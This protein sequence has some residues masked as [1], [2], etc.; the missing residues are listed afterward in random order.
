M[1]KHIK[2]KP[3]LVEYKFTPKGT[4]NTPKEFNLNRNA[5]FAKINKSL[6]MAIK[7]SEY[8]REFATGIL[9]ENNAPKSTILSFKENLDNPKRLKIESL[10]ARG[11]EL[12]S[13]NEVDNCVTANVS[14]PF[15]KI[16]VL[17]TLIN[18]YGTEDSKFNKPKNQ[19]L[20][21]SIS[22]IH[23]TTL[24][25][26]WF[27]SEPFPED[28]DAIENFE[29][30]FSVK[31]KLNGIV[32]DKISECANYC[33]VTFKNGSLSFQGRL[34]KIV[35]S[36]ISNLEM[37]QTLSGL[38]SEVRPASIASTDFTNSTYNEQKDWADSLTYN[39]AP[40][41]VS[42]CILDTGVNVAHPLLNKISPPH[43]QISSDPNWTAS[44]IPAM[45][46]PW[47]GLLHLVM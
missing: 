38:I 24:S 44:D 29:L 6:G 1:K 3:N 21:E 26:L 15:D 40:S 37:F 47:Q 28:I 30:W 34:V 14:I 42:I 39:V 10:D 4:P 18:Q 23:K 7:E 8:N 12:V 9:G 45:E 5:H 22:E 13:V 11:M 33:N 27:S 35:T 46:H 41:P 43:L 20:I 36:S 2:L 31:D 25:D 16:E 19:S 17:A 32:E